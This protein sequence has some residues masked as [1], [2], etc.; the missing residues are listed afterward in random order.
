ME[1]L[2]NPVYH[3]LITG[4]AH[5]AYGNRNAK[6]FDEEVSPF[7]GF[8]KN[9]EQGFEELY[10][11]LPPDRKILCATP[12][13]IA[14]TKGWELMAE[15]KGLQFIY[16]GEAP[17]P[18][19]EPQLVPLEKKHVEE[20]M[21]LARLTKPGPFGSRTIEFGHYHGIFQN[22]KLAAMAGQR[23]HVHRYTEIS[24]VCTHPEHLGKGYAATLMQHQMQFIC[25]H[26]QTPFLHVRA[27]NTRA[28]ALYE[29]LGFKQSRLMN[30]YV[31]RRKDAL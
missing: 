8:E 25:S 16:E 14:A 28:I 13:L 30:F 23:L 2:N 18:E 6:F 1:A 5:L 29:R 10:R 12:G 3:A 11:L 9:F 4:D 22:R 24:A 15:I 26:Q 17:K 27:D 21:E 19:H 7:A 31:L 20:M